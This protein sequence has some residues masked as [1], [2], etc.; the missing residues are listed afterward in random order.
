M[1]AVIRLLASSD[2]VVKKLVL[3]FLCTHAKHP[4]LL[5]AVNVLVKVYKFI[6]GAVINVYLN[7]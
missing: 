4:D 5:L 6:S 3:S 7:R 1:P 2:P